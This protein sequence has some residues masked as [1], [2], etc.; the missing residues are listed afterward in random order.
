MA[1]TSR[2]QVVRGHVFHELTRSLCPVCRRVVDAQVLLRDGAVYLRKRCPE[3]GWHEA[4]VSADAEWYVHNLKYN[5]PGAVPYDFAT[6]VERGC[7]ADCG[8]CPEHQQHTCVGVLE[9]TGRCNLA[10]PICFADSGAGGDLSLAEVE[11]ILDRLVETEGR[12]EVLQLSGGE[13]TLHPRLFE[14]LAAARARDIRHLMLNSN[15]LRLAEDAG[16]ARELAAYR[17]IVY[18]Q[19]DGLHAETYLALRGRD[20]RAIKEQA[21]ANFAAAG[22]PAVLVMTVVE[23]INDGELGEVLR[24]GLRHPAVL[25]VS[26]Q[27]ATFAGR[28]P[29]NA[30]SLHRS[31]LTSVLRALESQSE[32]VFRVSDFRPVPCPHPACSACTYAVV[33]G[34]EVLPLPRLLDVDDYLDFVTNRAALSVPEELRESVEALWSMAAMLGSGKSEHDLVRVTGCCDVPLP[35]NPA[36]FLRNFFMIQVHGFMDEHSFDVKRLMK[37]CIHQLL[38]DGRAVPFC[39]YNVLGYR[40]ENERA[41]RGR[42]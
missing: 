21:L 41:T 28:H 11:L 22:L 18:L 14:I 38:P 3:H 6:V 8:L 16:F 23:G 33:D 40:E 25:G 7:P 13:P 2:R 4:L 26:Y 9:I 24:Y 42:G 12:P 31:T 5:K 39:A 15:G 37:C 20:L 27:P 36:E 35:A 34:E 29:A 17:P 32:G 19:F 1:I 10:C 30:D